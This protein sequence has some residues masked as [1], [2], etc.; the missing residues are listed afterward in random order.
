MSS[1]TEGQLLAFTYGSAKKRKNAI[2]SSIMGVVPAVIIAFFRPLSWEQ[3]LLGFL[4]G[5][6]WANGFEYVYHRWLLH[7][8][9]SSLS[10]GHALHHI[11]ADT[12]EA[13]EHTT[14]G[15]SPLY[16][17]ALFV[18][19]GVPAVTGEALLRLGVLP[20]ILLGWTVYLIA[21]EEIHWRFHLG[22]WLPPS[23]RDARIYHLAHHDIAG[24]RYNVFLPLF[25]F[26][27]AT[28]KPPM[29]EIRIADGAAHAPAATMLKP[30]WANQLRELAFLGWALLLVLDYH[31]LYSRKLV[32]AARSQVIENK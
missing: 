20:G 22:G 24:G 27:F 16:V 12:P 21:L 4:I 13:A 30:G 29:A 17:V 25:D 5:L 1:A 19:N 9:F 23:L 32:A 6:V 18:I 11:T 2:T 8:P 10:K 28:I 26:L 3:W 31:F 7:S 15:Q 14:F